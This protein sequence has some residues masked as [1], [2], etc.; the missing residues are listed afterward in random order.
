MRRLQYALAPGGYLFLGS[1]ESISSVQQD[2]SA[3]SSKHKLYRI[4]RHG[5]PPL[6]PHSPVSRSRALALKPA[7]SGTAP[8][9][10]QRPSMPGK[11]YCC[12]AMH[13][14]ACC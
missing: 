6:E 2:F 11:R 10:T 5:A 9:A 14:S 1:S 13:R 12:A 4:L 7:Q 8:I 3:V